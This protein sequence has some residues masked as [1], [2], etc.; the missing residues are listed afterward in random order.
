MIIFILG[1]ILIPIASLRFTYSLVPGHSQCFYEIVE[2]NSR[3]QIIVRSSTPD[4]GINIF[5]P[6]SSIATLVDPDTF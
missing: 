4:V 1:L 2:R 6:S 3:F 5:T